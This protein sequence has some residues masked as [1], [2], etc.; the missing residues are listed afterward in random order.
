MEKI[1][2]ALLR[3]ALYQSARTVTVLRTVVVN[4]RVHQSPSAAQLA[5]HARVTYASHLVRP[6]VRPLVRHQ[7]PAPPAKIN[8]PPPQDVDGASPP[9]TMEIASRVTCPVRFPVHTTA[10]K[11]GTLEDIARHPQCA[12]PLFLMTTYVATSSASTAA[13]LRRLLFLTNKHATRTTVRTLLPVDP[14]CLIAR[15]FWPL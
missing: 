13:A 10:T 6:L 2:A 9:T 14:H 11:G 5:A 1:V 15:K 7:R 4:T 3:P 12:C 8:V